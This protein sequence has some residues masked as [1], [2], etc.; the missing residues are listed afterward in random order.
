MTELSHTMVPEALIE[1]FQG[2]DGRL[3]PFML[4]DSFNPS[5]PSG[6]TQFDPT[7]TDGGIPRKDILLFDYSFPAQIRDADKDGYLEPG[8]LVLATARSAIPCV[9]AIRGYVGDKREQHITF[10]H[11]NAHFWPNQTETARLIE[12]VE[13]LKPTTVTVLD[14]F[15]R[16]P[17]ILRASKLVLDAFRIQKFD[18]RIG[19]IPGNWYSNLYDDELGKIGLDGGNYIDYAKVSLEALADR[20]RH[21]GQISAEMATLS[22]A[23]PKET[24][25]SLTFKILKYTPPKA[26]TI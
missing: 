24:V 14:Q 10:G 26:Q 25:R 15:T 13:K 7:I 18:T 4:V 19:A 21:A 12:L 1:H 16:G 22:P 5:L 3:Y 20:M 6:F 11:I 9:D 23:T 2:M 17:T 8:A